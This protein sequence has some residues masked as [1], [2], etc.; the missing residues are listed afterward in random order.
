MQRLSSAAFV[1]GGVF[2]AGF[3]MAGTSA[4]AGFPDQPIQLIVQSS[5]GG[6]SDLF[7]R[8]LAALVEKDK[9]LPQPLVVE[10]KASGSGMVAFSYVAGKRGNPYFL[11]TA[12]PGLIAVPIARKTTVTFRDFTPIA[13]FAFDDFIVVVRNDPRFTSVADLVSVAKANPKR[14]LA[15]GTQVG[16]TDS[17]GAYLFEKAAGVQFNY[18]SFT[19]AGEVNAALMGGHVDL[20]ML[21]PGE[22][23]ELAKAKKVR[24]LCVM[25]EKRHPGAADVPTCREQGVDVVWRQHRGLAAP[26]D[27]PGGA[28]KT[29][30]DAFHKVTQTAGFKKYLEDNSIADGWMDGRA[31]GSWMEREAVRY[32]DILIGMG[33]VKK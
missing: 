5:A 22:A 31:F 14:V 25:T 15:G 18:I 21:N 12:G 26:A 3:C 9:L 11:V 1:L 23:L 33:L 16:S 24:V 19:G 29:L 2:L 6:G 4:A 30:E 28:R 7:A 13:N 32:E 10:N 27:V 8:T 20:A 17:M